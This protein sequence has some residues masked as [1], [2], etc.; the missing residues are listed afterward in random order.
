VALATILWLS[1]HHRQ[2]AGETDASSAKDST[3]AP[4]ASSS[5]NTDSAVHEGAAK[6]IEMFIP[7][8][9]R[10]LDSVGGY[11]MLNGDELLDRVLVVQKKSDTSAPRGILV[12]LQKPGDKWILLA[13]DWRLDQNPYDMGDYETENIYIHDKDHTLHVERYQHGPR[14][15]SHSTYRMSGEDLVLWYIEAYARG[16]GSTT[17]WECDIPGGVYKEEITHTLKIPEEVTDSVY[18]LSPA[19]IKFGDANPEVVAAEAYQA[20]H[21]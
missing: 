20:T 16:A 3:A 9:Y 6:S 5:I 17:L 8:G 21:E 11:G 10:I 1:C 14:G 12:L 13:Q 2:P 15:N 19:R 7:E 18:R 4:P